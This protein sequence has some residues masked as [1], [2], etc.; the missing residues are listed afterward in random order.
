[1]KLTT[2]LFYLLFV[3]FTI[4]ANTGNIIGKINDINGKPL[5]YVYVELE[6]TK[7]GGMTSNEGVFII[8][9]VPIGE[10]SAVIK[11]NDYRQVVEN[12]EVL[13]NKTTELEITFKID[14]NKIPKNDLPEDSLNVKVYQMPQIEILDDRTGVMGQL[15]GAAGY[16]SRADL[17]ELAPINGNEAIRRISGVHVLEEEGAGL[18]V[19]VGIRGL[20]PDKSRNILVLEDGV[21]VALAPYGEPEMYYTPAMDR[22]S[23]VEILKGSGSIL[24]GPQTIGGVMNYITADPPEKSTT[25]LRLKGG[26][27]GY[28]S[29]YA[30]Y[31]TTFG[32]T[33]IQVSYLR[34]QA[35][36]LGN[37]NF[38]LNDIT[39]KLKFKIN[40]K[41]SIGLKLGIYQEES[42]ATYIGITQTMYDKGGDDFTRLA[43]DD[44]LNVDRYSI[45]STYRYD[46]NSN[47]QINTTAFAYTTKRNWR[48]QDFSSSSTATNQ[49]GV[50][51]GDPTQPGGALYMRNSTG[52]RDR[53]F[54]VGG[55][56]SRLKWN[57][58]LGKIK[59]ILNAGA[60]VMHETAFEQT[61]NGT[62]PNAES[63]AMVGDEVRTGLAGSLFAQNK[64]VIT[65]K[66]TVTAGLRYEDYTYERQINRVSSK[67]TLISNTTKSNQLIPGLGFNYT[68]SEKLGVFGGLHRGFAPP[69]TKDAIDNSGLDLELDAELS[70][71][72][73]LGLRTKVQEILFVEA[74]GFYMDFSNQVIPVSQSSGGLGAG[75]L[76]GGRTVHSGAELSLAIDFGKWLISKDYSLKAQVSATYVNAFFN[77]DRF[78]T[79]Q[80]STNP[81]FQDVVVNIKGNK[82]P[83]A[84]ST[85]LSSSLS[86]KAPFGLGLQLIGTYIGEQYTDELN[87]GNVYDYIA[88]DIA[89]PNYRYVQ[90]TANGRTGKLDSYFLLDA[91]AWYDIPKTKASVNI[92]VK[93]I[94]NERYI[95]SRRPQGI[96]VGLPRLISAGFNY[97][98]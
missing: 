58:N 54:E 57:Y 37:L 13:E 14:R 26:E 2:T 39:A 27:G 60:R 52:N 44:R 63:G 33:G 49:T 12:I 15:P 90:A 84:P 38:R 61:V 22:M 41:S 30:G 79:T 94:T 72:Y 77:S 28:F 82:T 91:T 47:L 45:S 70:W 86:F 89:D 20:D 96:R 83:Y 93:N 34:R 71:N 8:N 16:I 74:T 31:G 81:D 64:L 18:R 32:N 76:N 66:F 48:R 92:S 36:N 40:E 9:N 23:G 95:V 65:E 10:Y 19:N 3:S 35:D 53:Q 73:E 51:F 98:F 25:T 1:M 4:S 59:N 17:K 56:E 69:R 24:F 68:F 85:F 97:N 21:P 87:T 75:L 7:I 6:K 11:R 43:P 55:L 67:D 78:V 46:V 29:G 5:S 80:T 42:N 50:V 62:K 88:K